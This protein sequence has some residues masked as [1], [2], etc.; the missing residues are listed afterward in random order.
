MAEIYGDLPSPKSSATYNTLH[1]IQGMKTDLYR[2][3]RRSVSTML[4]RELSPG[5]ISDPLYIDLTGID[6]LVFFL[7][8]ASM[9]I[10]Q[11]CPMVSQARGG[12]LCEELGQSRINVFCCLS[13]R[14]Q[15]PE[16]R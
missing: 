14:E 8:P 6:G 15:V 10:L 7:Q 4:S 16:R 11:E 1:N 12:I 9:E 2:Y 5:A 13:Y 3:Q